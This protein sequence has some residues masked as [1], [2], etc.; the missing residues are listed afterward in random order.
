MHLAHQGLQALVNLQATVEDQL[1][2]VGQCNAAWGPNNQRRAKGM[3]R[4]GYSPAQGRRRNMFLLGATR[5]GAFTRG[6]NKKAQ[7]V[8]ID[9]RAGRKL[10]AG[11]GI[12]LTGAVLRPA[13]W[14]G[15]VHGP[16]EAVDPPSG[17]EC[18]GRRNGRL[19]CSLPTLQPARSSAQGC[20]GTHASSACGRCASGELQDSWVFS[21]ACT[22]VCTE[23]WRLR[24]RTSTLRAAEA[25]SAVLMEKCVATCPQSAAPT[26]L[27]PMMAIW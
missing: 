1:A 20:S 11:N 2:R 3:L 13:P 16:A 19:C 4:I 18:A 26:A 17:H 7:V 15:P 12:A 25:S 23:I 6:S 22:S 10:Y 27:P 9:S 14:P 21:S 8:G 5:D 24:H